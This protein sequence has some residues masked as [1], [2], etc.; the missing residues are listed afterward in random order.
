MSEILEKTIKTGFYNMKNQKLQDINNP[1]YKDYIFKNGE[2]NVYEDANIFLHGSCQLFALALHKKFGY[3]AYKLE[4]HDNSFAH[5][6]CKSN[7]K[8]IDFFIDVRG[9][10]SDINDVIS[11]FTSNANYNIDNYKFVDKKTLEDSE[12]EGL[13]FADY[14]IKKYSKFY[15]VNQLNIRG[16]FKI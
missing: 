4:T 16:N 3:D 5:C 14:I 6:F 7:Y 13:K 12:L 10:T 1:N 15:D 9:I 8:G 2:D 11:E